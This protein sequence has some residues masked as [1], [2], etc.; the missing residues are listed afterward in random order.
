MSMTGRH[1]RAL[2]AALTLLTATGFGPAAAGELDL[3]RILAPVI[4]LEARIPD[5]ARSATTLG[6]VRGGTGVVIDG[7]GLVVTIGYLILEAESVELLPGGLGGERIPAQVVAWDHATGLGLVRSTRPLEVAPMSLGES[8]ALAVDDAVIAA[9]WTRQAGMLPA[10]ITDRGTYT[11]YW[12]YLLENALYVSP[13]HPAFP[14]AALI[15]LD[16]KLVGIGG[17]AHFDSG[18]EEEIA[19]T[20]FIPIDTLKPILAELLLDGRSSVRRPWLGLYC[21][22]IDGGLRVRRVPADGPAKKAG[23]RHGDRL[24]A[25][26]GTPVV[27]LEDFYR[28]LWSMVRPGDKVSIEIERDGAIFAVEIVSIDRYERLDSPFLTQ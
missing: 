4:A 26:A 23:V 14:G 16:G 15:G 24:I 28:R 25:L 12:E 22:E 8:S 21:E 13:I 20:V 2:L 9:S 1:G 10:V 6:T 7:A 11:G 17:F 5:G 19:G 27:S 3:E 18:E